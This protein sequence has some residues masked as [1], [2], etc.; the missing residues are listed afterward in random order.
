M[1]TL[2]PAL[3]IGDVAKKVGIS[4]H[5]IRYYEKEGLLDG[6]LRTAGGFR[7]YGQGT[8]ER[9]LFIQKAKEFGLTL[10][11]IHRIT[12]CGDQGLGPCCDLTVQIFN[13]KIK[14]LESKVRELN[15]TKRKIKTLI[16]GWAH[17]KGNKN[18]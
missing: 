13:D 5:A 10:E 9:L 11:E 1:Q 8:V 3:K 6:P 12:R 15:E 16:S 7:L 2:L 4:V 18:E 14:E 17:K